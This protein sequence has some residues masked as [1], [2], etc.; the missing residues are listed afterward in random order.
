MCLASANKCLPYFSATPIYP[1]NPPEP[2]VSPNPVLPAKPQPLPTDKDTEEISKFH[3]KQGS[4][5]L[6]KYMNLEGFL[7]KSLKI[8]SALKKV[9]ENHSKTRGAQW[10]SGRVLESRP[11]VRGFE[12][13]RRH[14]VVSLSKTH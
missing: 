5:R 11:K 4:H 7:E 9:L 13:H 14:C 10:L 3:H 2:Q 8:K 12:P 1:S 6:E